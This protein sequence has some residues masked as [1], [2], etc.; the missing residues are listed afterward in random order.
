MTQF[1]TSLNSHSQTLVFIDPSL[2]DY[3]SL[4]AGVREGVQVDV[5]DRARDGIDQITTSI[6]Q[7]AA[8]GEIDAV[9]IFAHGSPDRLYLPNAVL[10]T[11]SLEKYLQ[12]WQ[13]WQQLL[14]QKAT[15]LL[16]GCQ[17]AHARGA[18]FVKQL[19]NLTGKAIA[20]SAN[21]VGNAATVSNWNLEFTA[22]ESD[23]PIALGP[24]IMAAYNGVFATINVTN[25]N[26][27]GAGSL[28]EAIAL[29][30]PGDSIIL[31]PSLAGGTI[32]LNSQ[33]VIDKDLTIVGL[34]DAENNPNV[35]IS[36]NNA[37]R[38]FEITNDGNFNPVTVTI[39]NTIV[40]NGKSNGTGEAGAGGGIKTASGTTLTLA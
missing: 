16:Y 10:S 19:S 2:E 18:E 4:V 31:D 12:H 14:S 26:D 36:G 39:E 38:V 30:N 37:H 17:L 11:D 27:S 6:Q 32:T 35:T 7:A 9:H 28:R 33:L 40:A 24:E 13:V 20:A 34:V 22:G 15:I 29:A 1:Q 8:F 3:K 25:I 23:T 21:L 5:L